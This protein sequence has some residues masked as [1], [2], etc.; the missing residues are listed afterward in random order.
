MGDVFNFNISCLEWIDIEWITIYCFLILQ[1]DRFKE[2]S[3]CDDGCGVKQVRKVL[4]IYGSNVMQF[5]TND[6]GFA[7]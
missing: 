4:Y 5:T 7:A 6:Y 3:G 2:D 1:T